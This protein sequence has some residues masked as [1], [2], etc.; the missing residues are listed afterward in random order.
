MKSVDLKAGEIYAVRH[1]YEPCMLLDTAVHCELFPGRGNIS[2]TPAADHKPGRDKSKGWGFDRRDYGYL[3]LAGTR[4]ALAAVDWVAAYEALLETG[5][6]P[7]DSDVRVLL[8]TSLAS[9]LGPFERVR[10]EQDA[11]RD[12]EAERRRKESAAYNA[13]VDRLNTVLPEAHR[14]WRAREE[15]GAPL[16]LTLTLEQARLIAERLGGQE[17]R[18]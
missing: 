2:Y 15:A 16:D 10:A 17:A 11:Q 12:V 3:L 4:E 14:I 8:A 5:R 13:I 9:I 1:R 6:L 7:E 18:P